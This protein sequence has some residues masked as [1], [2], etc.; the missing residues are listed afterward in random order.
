MRFQNMNIPA[1]FEESS[2][3]KYIKGIGANQKTGT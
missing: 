1:E 2:L 3:I